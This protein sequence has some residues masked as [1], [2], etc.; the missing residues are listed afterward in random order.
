MPLHHY[1]HPRIFRTSYG[2]DVLNLI[3]HLLENLKRNSL[4]SVQK[5]ENVI[6]LKASTFELEKNDKVE[7]IVHCAFDAF[8]VAKGKETN[9]ATQKLPF[10]NL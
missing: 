1:W 6:K 7:K 2:P 5:Y 4:H 3:Q 9:G 8:L 10:H